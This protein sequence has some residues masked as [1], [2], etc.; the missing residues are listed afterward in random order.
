MVDINIFCRAAYIIHSSMQLF[1]KWSEPMALDLP[2]DQQ[3]GKKLE[4]EGREE[5]QYLS[6]NSPVPI[7]PLR[8][9]L[10]QAMTVFLDH[11]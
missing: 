7:P 1:I 10:K 9:P 2:I 4:A 3:G 6:L 5:L 11:R 8:W